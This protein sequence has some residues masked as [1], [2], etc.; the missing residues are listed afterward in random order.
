MD[1]T[2]LDLRFSRQA[3]REGEAHALFKSGEE[4]QTARRVAEGFV[5]GVE[6]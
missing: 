1:V 2:C 4:G 6:G 3:T 5:L